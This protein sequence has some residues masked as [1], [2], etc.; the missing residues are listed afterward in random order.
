MM[1]KGA[2]KANLN[3][4]RVYD[5][6]RAF[7]SAV[8]IVPANELLARGVRKFL[9]SLGDFLSGVVI[10]TPIFVCDKRP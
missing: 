3:S 9:I 5:L 4:E 6:S 7:A 1:P 8:T 10:L 2:C